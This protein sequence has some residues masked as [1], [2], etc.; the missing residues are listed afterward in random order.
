MDIEQFK[1]YVAKMNPKIYL[2]DLNRYIQTHATLSKEDL[3][4][5]VACIDK[6]AEQIVKMNESKRLDIKLK[7]EL[8]DEIERLEKGNEEALRLSIKTIMN[9]VVEAIGV[10]GH[11][12]SDR[13]CQTCQVVTSIIGQP[14]GY[15]W[16]QALAAKPQKG[17]D[18][19]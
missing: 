5:L 10:D 6:Q 18:N 3:E 9:A 14:F 13:P 16:Y 12:W 7:A 17:Q 8:Q 11:Q 4:E 2:D 15:Y 19:V 1:R